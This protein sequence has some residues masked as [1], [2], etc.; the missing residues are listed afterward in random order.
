MLMDG[1]RGG[2]TRRSNGCGRGGVRADSRLATRLAT[3]RGALIVRFRGDAVIAVDGYVVVAYAGRLHVLSTSTGA[4]RT[5]R[6]A[7]PSLPRSAMT[8]AGSWRVNLQLSSSLATFGIASYDLE[9]G[10]RPAHILQRGDSL[11]LEGSEAALAEMPS[12][13]AVWEGRRPILAEPD[14]SSRRLLVHDLPWL[15]PVERGFTVC[16]LPGSKRV[17][18]LDH[19]GPAVVYD[20]ADRSV[21]KQLPVFFPA[22]SGPVQCVAGSLWLPDAR[23]DGS[24]AQV[25][26]QSWHVTHRAHFRSPLHLS[27]DPTGTFGAVRQSGTDRISVVELSSG[28]IRWQVEPSPRSRSVDG[29]CLVGGDRLVF[30]S[31]SSGF[32]IV[33]AEAEISPE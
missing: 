15:G 14:R 19:E 25:D 21:V 31:P 9:R 5:V 32:E 1:F 22:S 7:E 26:A 4:V 18:V 2:G 6:V 28:A 29:P 23:V 24:L 33:D 8:A 11:V 30:W 17:L 10:T 12:A 3:A 16:S 27:V 13:F 20:L